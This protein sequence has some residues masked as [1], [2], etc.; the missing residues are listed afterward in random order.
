MTQEEDIEGLAGEYVLGSLTPEERRQ[1]DV[2]RER[3]RTLAAA[4]ADWERRL[5]PLADFIPGEEPPAQLREAII[6]RIWQAEAH[7]ANVLPLHQHQHAVRR[8]RRIAI[9]ASALAAVLAVVVVIA[10][11][12]LP[13][14]PTTLVA[15]LQRSAAGQ[16]A[17]ESGDVR[18]SPAFVVAIDTKLKS[19][20]VTP[21][22]ARSVPKRSYQLWLTQ[23]K[24]A[25]VPLGIVAP[26]SATTLPWPRANGAEQLPPAALRD[27][28]LAIS[29]EPEG[30]SPS[31]TPSGPILYEGKLSGAG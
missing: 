22:A 26:A 1:V 7:P 3:D 24:A 13:T 21:L 11:Q 31:S 2:R 12:S 30:G 6:R 5:A 28:T 25:P 9:A 23:P 17:D 29:L 14:T 27:A 4:I 16:T 10:L 15:V 8:W 20:V 19:I 18:G